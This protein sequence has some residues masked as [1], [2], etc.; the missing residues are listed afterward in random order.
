M[1]YSFKNDYAEGAHPR[2]LDALIKNNLTQQNG[3]GLDEYSQN[4]ARLIKEKCE[5]PN[6][7]VHFVSG[8][9]QANLIVISAFL[10]AHESVVAAQTGHIFTNE[11]GAI[12]AT[13]HKVHGVETS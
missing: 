10:R 13:G 6:A 2:I 9:T 7:A 5:N 11:A 4:A 3:Y 8:G 12:E 1:T